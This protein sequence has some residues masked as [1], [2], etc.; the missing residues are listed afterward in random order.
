[1][2]WSDQ[3]HFLL[4]YIDGWV[5]VV[6]YLGNTCHKDA[7]WDGGNVMFWAMFCW[8]PLGPAITIDVS[9]IRIIYLV[10]VADHVHPLIKMVL[11]DGR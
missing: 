4:H 11:P 9:L 2:V 10:F 3:S 7:Q 5:P 6:V 1:M 8:E